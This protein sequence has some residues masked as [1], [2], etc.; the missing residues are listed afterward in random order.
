MH[1]A[2]LQHI[3]C[4]PAA[5]YL[6]V[7]SE[8]GSVTTVRMGSDD[9]PQPSDV[10]AVV[11]MGGP[12]GVHDVVEY[13]WLRDEVTFLTRAIDHGAAVWGVCLGAQLLAT[14]LGA[15]VYPGPEPEVGVAEVTLTESATTDPVLSGVSTGFP[16][17]HWHGDTF[18]LPEDAV[19]LA[20]TARYGNQ[21]FRHGLSYGLQFHLETSAELAATW[22]HVP[23]YRDSLRETLGD[24]GEQLLLDG[25]RAHETGILTTAATVMTRWLSLLGDRTPTS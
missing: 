7:L 23:A 18:D 1:I 11:T 22:L 5:A 8:H 2:V 4:E 3:D 10:D 19:H 20:S 14:A 15:E 24:R 17:L 16:A 25:L 9:L 13:P 12:M 6:P 21:A